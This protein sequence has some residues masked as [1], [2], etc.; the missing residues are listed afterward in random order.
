MSKAIY[1][2]D[3]PNAVSIKIT[4]A[5]FENL[6]RITEIFNKWDQ[7][8]LTPAELIQEQFIEREQAFMNL[9][10][11]NPG[12]YQSTMPGALCDIYNNA[13]DVDAL[14]AAFIGNGFSVQC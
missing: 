2:I 13:P 6:K 10:T 12:M 1:T 7:N 11:P 9:D 14:R 5:A 8:E 3:E 4:G